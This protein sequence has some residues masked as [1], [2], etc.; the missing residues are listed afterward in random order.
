[1]HIQLEYHA[2]SVTIQTPHGDI[3]VTLDFYTGDCRGRSKTSVTVTNKSDQ[4]MVC[5]NDFSAYPEN[6]PY[7]ITQIICAD[8]E[9]L[10]E[11][12]QE[13]HPV[14]SGEEGADD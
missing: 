6:H 2:D 10:M 12:S 13:T 4:P 1:M 3:V 7:H 14:N 8:D 9:W 11:G 5:R